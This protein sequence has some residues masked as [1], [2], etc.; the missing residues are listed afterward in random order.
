VLSLLLLLAVAAGLVP[1]RAAVLGV[2]LAVAALVTAVLSVDATVV[3]LTR[4]PRHRSYWAARVSDWSARAS[5]N[6]RVRHSPSSSSHDWLS[7]GR[8]AKRTSQGWALYSS[9]K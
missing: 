5:L 6:G 3:L 4:A 7:G 9:P 1:W 8:S 2:V